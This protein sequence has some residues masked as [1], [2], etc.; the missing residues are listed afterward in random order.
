MTQRRISLLTATLFVLVTAGPLAAQSGTQLLPRPGESNTRVGSRGANFLSIGVGARALAMGNAYAALAD[1]ADA[2]YWNPAGIASNPRFTAIVSYNDMFGDF[3]LDHI[4]GGVTVPAGEGAFGLSLTS[5]QSG[6]MQRTTED[7]PE[8]GDPLFGDTFEWTDLAVALSYARQITDR[9]NVGLSVKY[10]QSGISEATANF[11][12]GDAGIQFRTGLLG[13]TVAASLLNLGTSGE[14]EGALVRQFVTSGQELFPTDRTIAINLDTRDWDMP[15]TFTFSV[16]WD[17]VGSPEALLTPNPDH[18]LLM[19][20][21]ATDAIDTSVMG[22]VG[23][24]YSYRE[25]FFV[26]GGKFFMNEDNASGFRDFAHG[27]TGG[28][29]VAIPL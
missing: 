9:L 27:L 3:G 28:L 20:T 17:L 22:R 12:G 25:L 23:L 11:F 10:V 18:R 8:G 19:L 26:R 7:F 2:L 15:T 4:Y 21:D 29:G 16:L 5:F 14:Y 6:D 1:G 24:E 13:T